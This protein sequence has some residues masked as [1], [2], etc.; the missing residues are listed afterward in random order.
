MDCR[1]Q[2]SARTDETECAH[3]AL[4]VAVFTDCGY[5]GNRV[6]AEYGTPD[7]L[8]FVVHYQLRLVVRAYRS[9]QVPAMAHLE[10]KELTEDNKWCILRQLVRIR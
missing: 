3:F 6:L 5:P 9:I 8:L 4:P 7:I 10:Q 2:G 1:P